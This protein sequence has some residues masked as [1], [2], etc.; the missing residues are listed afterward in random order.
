MKKFVET[1]CFCSPSLNKDE[2]KTNNKKQNNLEFISSLVKLLPTIALNNQPAEEK[3]P[4]TPQKFVKN[5]RTA[6]IL[7]KNRQQTQ[8]LYNKKSGF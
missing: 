2:I 1:N 3:Q 4:Q 6:S 8:N 7:E 5:T